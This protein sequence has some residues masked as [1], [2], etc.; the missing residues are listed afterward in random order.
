MMEKFC[1][2]VGLTKVNVD[3][4]CVTLFMLSCAMTSVSA[5]CSMADDVCEFWLEVETRLTMM[6]GNVAVFP[7]NGKLYRYDVTNVTTADTVNDNEVVTADGWEKQRLVVT[8][9]RTMPG[10]SIEVYEGQTVRIH[11]KNLM[12]NTGVTIHWHGIHQ[13]GTPWMDGVGYVTQCPIMPGQQ[14]TYNFKA[15]PKGTLWYHAHVGTLLSMGLLGAFIVRERVAPPMEEFIM[16]LQDWNHNMDSDLLHYKM[17]YGNYEDRRKLQPSHSLEGAAFSMFIFTSGLI[18]GKGRYY[19]P[20]GTHNQAPL[21]VY[22]VVQYKSYR[23]RVIGAGNLYPFRVSI[24]DHVITL[25]A[26]DGDNFQPIEVESFI[27]NP[28]ERYDFVITANQ[29]VGNYWIRAVTLEVNVT[30]HVAEAILRYNGSRDV[31]PV[32][33]RRNCSE[34]N[35][36]LVFNCPFSYFPH[37]D[38][39]DCKHIDALRSVVSPDTPGRDLSSSESIKDIF[40]NFAFP[41]TTWTP[42]S[43]N[44]HHFKPPP[45]AALTQPLEVNT[46]C[47]SSD[48]GE[49]KLCQCSYSISLENNKVYQFVFLNMG[50]GKGW[51]H[52]IHLHG[53]SFHV[54]KMGYPTYDHTTGKVIGENLDIDCRGNPDREKSYCNAASW[55]NSSWGGNNVPGLELELPVLKDT[56]I[57]PTG[58]Y[59]VVR[60]KADNPGLWLMHCHIELH[61]TDGMALVFNESY[62]LHPKAP[63]GFPKCGDFTYQEQKDS[64]EK[65]SGLIRIE[66]FIAV[67]IS[68][69]IALLIIIVILSIA[70]RRSRHNNSNNV[71]YYSMAG[72]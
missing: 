57:V 72:D 53:H 8:V 27:I 4:I 41:G 25:I 1:A 50:L 48:C 14:F 31:E 56:I 30:D 39:T 24:D 68:V 10:P 36:C 15:Y 26:S 62:A 35:R 6:A 63:V 49:D 42:G 22:P 13:R 16:M 52:P 21:T 46:L 51:A 38:F 2:D 69:T 29:S 32:T 18:N 64:V 37:A 60:I 55:A 58:G 7:T 59:V 9:N 71:P 45:V 40:L 70:L 67:I 19:Y 33:K 17:L 20:N 54:V 44:G 23:F 11:V 3:F 66:I 61:N 65:E 34:I 12:L 5:G 28:G 47:N 43:V